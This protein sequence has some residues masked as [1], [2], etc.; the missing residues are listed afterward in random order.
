MKHLVL[1]TLC[2]LVLAGCTP[3]EPSAAPSLTEQKPTISPTPT[4][5]AAPQAVEIVV[6]PQESELVI[7]PE[8][9]GPIVIGEPMPDF[10]PDTALALWDETF[11]GFDN[12][13]EDYA[14]WVTNYPM[15]PDGKY[16]FLAEVDYPTGTVSSPITGITVQSTEIRTAS[17]LGIGSTVASLESEYGADLLPYIDP[18]YSAYVVEGPVGQLVFWVA[19]H[20]GQVVSFMFVSVDQ[21]APHFSFHVTGCA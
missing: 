15:T 2:A 8:G 7:S 5:S 20:E 18:D 17:G 9:L 16:P 14:N 1:V 12:P 11:C 4:V 21:L 3:A 6:K 19:E 13:S 10:E